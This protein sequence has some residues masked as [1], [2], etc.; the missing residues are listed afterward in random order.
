M[1]C[2]FLYC[3]IHFYH[4]QSWRIA[5]T[6]TLECKV[7]KRVAPQVLFSDVAASAAGKMAKI[8][9]YNNAGRKK[10]CAHVMLEAYVCGGI[11]QPEKQPR[12]PPTAPHSFVL[13]TNT[14]PH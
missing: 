5:H 6:P 13:P 3:K 2:S 9:I 4:A 1:S 8:H 12:E 10:G 7:A 11:T 14:G